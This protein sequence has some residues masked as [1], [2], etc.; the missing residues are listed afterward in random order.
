[1]SKCVI[2]KNTKSLPIA[3]TQP[4]FENVLNRQFSV[5]QPN[6]AYA[7]DITC[8]W[9]QEGW[10]YLAV[11]IDLFSRRVVGWSISSRM[12]TKLVCDVLK[13]AIWQRQPVSGLI[14]HSDQGS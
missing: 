2:V 1:M 5:N 13:M 4:V 8:V 10:L 11:V 7:S 12:K 9:T 6:Q 3:I 14:A